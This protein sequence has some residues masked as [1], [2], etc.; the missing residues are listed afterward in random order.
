MQPVKLIQRRWWIL[1]HLSFSLAVRTLHKRGKKSFCCECLPGQGWISLG[2]K[3]CPQ[4]FREKVSFENSKTLKLADSAA[5]EVSHWRSHSSRLRFH[6]QYL[7]K[8]SLHMCSLFAHA[9]SGC[10]FNCILFL[11]NTIFSTSPWKTCHHLQ[12]R[13]TDLRSCKY[14]FSS[15]ALLLFLITAVLIHFTILV[16]FFFLSFCKLWQLEDCE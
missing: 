6:L 2:G 10:L 16:L 15:S 7:F 4:S 12:W 14:L 13:M 1:L 11:K 3:K 5:L 9:P 8:I